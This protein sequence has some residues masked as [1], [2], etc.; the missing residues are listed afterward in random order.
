MKIDS[1]EKLLQQIYRQNFILTIIYLLISLWWSSLSV[2]L[3]VLAGSLIAIS[4]YSWLQGILKT[5][6]EQAGGHP[7]RK[8]RWH[9][10]FRIVALGLVLFLLFFYAKVNAIALCLGLSV[11]VLS[12]MIGILRFAIPAGR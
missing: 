6:L 5:V 8:F 11:V 4:S 7:G 2:T 12:I 1:E 9:Y 10:G 3:S